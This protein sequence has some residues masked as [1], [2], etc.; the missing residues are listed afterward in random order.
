MA[1]QPT[2]RRSVLAV[3]VFVT[4]CFGW[5]PFNFFTSNDVRYDQAEDA[6][7][8]NEGVGAGDRSARGIAFCAETLDTTSWHGITLEIELKAKS[9]AR[10]GLAVFLEF[11]DGEDELPALLVSQ[12]QDHLAIRS[13]RDRSAVSRGYSEIGHRDLFDGQSFKRLFLSS[14]LNRTDLY[15]DG[16]LVESRRDFP[17]LGKD[18][19]F[20]GRLLIGNSADG[21]NPFIGEIRRVA[22]Y[23]SFYADGT[24]S[25]AAAKP[26]LDFDMSRGLLP[27]SLSIPDQFELVKREFFNS[28]RMEQLTTEEYTRDIV[29]NTLG[30]IPVGICFASMGRRRFRSSLRVFLF[31]GIASFSLSMMI[32]WGQGYLAH[33]DS[34]QLDVLLNTVSGTIAVLVPRRWILFL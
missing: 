34:S 1:L 28:K 2:F 31:V 26:V 11:F 17:L 33:R 22:V 23:D 3:V 7:V 12:W 14:E 27:L 9:H 10:S 16:K 19:K 4:L 15:V 21:T 29:I 32:E 6:L 25:F 20:I 30:F 8:F 13:R 24:D 5:W 18:N